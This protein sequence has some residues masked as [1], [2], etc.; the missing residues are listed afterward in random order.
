MK[1]ASDKKAPAKRKSNLKNTKGIFKGGVFRL[2]FRI[3]KLAFIIFVGAS[4]FFVLLFKFVNPP[5]TLL[6][7]IR[8]FEQKADGKPW[9]IDKEWKSFDE[10]ADPMKRGA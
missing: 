1:K 9:K 2:V 6:M 7:V 10:I 4:I 3:I 5:V 8:G